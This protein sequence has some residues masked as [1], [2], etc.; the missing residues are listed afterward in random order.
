MSSKYGHWFYYE[1]EKDINKA[2]RLKISSS[3]E[4]KRFDVKNYLKHILNS[5]Y[6]RA[7]DNKIYKVNDE[8]KKF[9]QEYIPRKFKF[10]SQM[11]WL[12]PI[13]DKNSDNIYLFNKTKENIQNVSGIVFSNISIPKFN[14]YQIPIDYLIGSKEALKDQY[15]VQGSIDHFFEDLHGQYFLMG[16]WGHGVNS[17]AF[18]YIRS[19]PKSKI[20]FRLPYGGVYMDNDKEKVRI[21]KF[22]TRFFDL[23]NKLSN[24]NVEYLFVMES[25]GTSGFKLKLKDQKEVFI[26]NSSFY[27]SD[28]NFNNLIENIEI[29][30]RFGFVDKMDIDQN[31]QL[32]PNIHNIDNLLKYLP[33]FQDP[34]NFFNHITNVPPQILSKSSIG[35]LRVFSEDVFKENIIRGIHN[36]INV[37]IEV[38][39]Y[40]EDQSLIQHSD[41]NTLRNIFR[42]I[43]KPFKNDTGKLKE[44]IDKGVILNLLIR[45]QNIK[46]ELIDRCYGAIVGLAVGD[47][48]GMPLEFKSPG[49]FEPVNEMIGGGPFNLKPGEWT[50][51]TNMA[52]CLAESLIETGKF[53]PI[54]QLNHYLRWYRDGHLSVNGRCFD[55]GNTTRKALEIFEENKYPYPGP[56]YEHSAGNGSIMRLSPVPIFYLNNPLVAVQ[57]SGKS[58][59]TT[60]NHPLTVDACRYLGGLIYGAIIGISKDELL[61]ERYSPVQG[62]WNKNTMA[63]EIEK[64]ACGSFKRKEPPEIRGRGYVVKSLEAALWAFYKSNSFEEGCLMAVNLGEDADTTGAIYGQL[65][66]AYYGF[67]NIPYKW[68]KKLVKRDM[69]KSIIKRLVQSNTK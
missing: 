32:M 33:Y 60:H 42:T 59:R 9:F 31:V 37:E 57:M 17:Y 28:K 38:Q 26:N 15:L 10:K 45:L 44:M 29:Y 4:A 46:M 36:V 16:F 63:P 27:Y 3:R 48:M 50:D 22:L 51:D 30:K 40:I 12:G 23:E 65:A 67:S 58:S 43:I 62:Y 5:K 52:L 18:Y 21:N 61:S 7:D 2:I 1:G 13:T 66:G 55:I 53:D 49:S 19:D 56:D 64:V 41:L 25:M 47:A 69:I 39:K 14:L 68:R 34:E 54:D 35:I 11:M 8:P 24:E 20:F 6:F